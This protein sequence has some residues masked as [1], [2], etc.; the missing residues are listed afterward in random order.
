[1]NTTEGI[2]YQV[3]AIDYEDFFQCPKD[4]QSHVIRILSVQAYAE[5]CGATEVGRQIK[6]AP[7]AISRKRLAKIV[8][9]E[10]S[11]AYSLYEIL[12]KIN[13]S[14]SESVAIVL[15]HRNT[16][17]SQSLTGVESVGHEEHTWLDVILNTFFLD[18]A[19]SY[20]V[21]NFAQSSF[22]PWSL[23]C[24]SIYKDEQWHVRFGEQ[25]LESYIN[26]YSLDAVKAKF[27]TWFVYAI[28]FFGSPV[29]RSHDDLKR[30][31]IKRYSNEEL[32]QQFIQKV[33]NLLIEKGWQTLIPQISTDYPYTL[34][35]SN[36]S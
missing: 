2:D 8:Y 10:A 36:P 19:G 28:N 6:L 34:L 26:D 35:G 22:K 17:K 32:R 23:A 9:D 31:G 25:A 18:R 1:M 12:Q 33:H 16:P 15:G 5:Y 3:G 11:H 27:G 20:M 4:Y 30:Y 13:I 7:D 14:E 21:G 29:S 24:Q